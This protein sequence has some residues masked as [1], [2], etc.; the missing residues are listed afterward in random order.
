MERQDLCVGSPFAS[1]YKI[2][3]L[4]ESSVQEFDF[5]R[6]HQNIPHFSRESKRHVS[7]NRTINLPD[8]KSIV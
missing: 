3:T 8:L 5:C 6:F 2:K 4:N 7:D 1:C